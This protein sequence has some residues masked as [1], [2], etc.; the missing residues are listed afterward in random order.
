MKKLTLTSLAFA[1]ATTFAATSALASAVV[2]VGDK[3][4]LT[5]TG[6]NGLN[7]GYLLTKSTGS[8]GSFTT[9]CIEYNEHFYYGETLQVVG[10]SYGAKNGGQGGQ[11]STGIYDPISA[12]TA[13]L[14]TNFIDTPGALSSVA[15]W[16]TN[17]S[18]N[19]TAMQ[20]AIW[21]LEEEILSTGNALADA[22]ITFAT[23]K[24]DAG[25]TDIGGRV[26]ALNLLRA[27]G[28]TK[29]QDQLY[30][31]PVPLPAAGLLM[32]SALGLGGL[33]TKRRSAQAAA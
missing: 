18:T 15:G 25:W 17:A 2:A 24:V 23:G 32:L 14:Y 10:I 9:F 26:H 28:I 21:K 1:V 8:S 19:A 31:A 30:L 4:T 33:L 7:D 13:F 11:D 16:T 29:G 22:L 6:N 5:D 3:I 12:Q 27:D 20:L